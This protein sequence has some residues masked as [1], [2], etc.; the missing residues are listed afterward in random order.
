MV[1]DLFSGPELRFLHFCEIEIREKILMLK[2]S[3]LGPDGSL[4][5]ADSVAIAKSGE[6]ETHL[7]QPLLRGRLASTVFIQ[8]VSRGVILP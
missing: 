6:G 5:V 2:V 4:G 3:A 7:I 1:R 8:Y